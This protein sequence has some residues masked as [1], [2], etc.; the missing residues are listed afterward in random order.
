MRRT[1]PILIAATALVAIAAPASAAQP[2]SPAP[3]ETTGTATPTFRWT[4]QYP[5]NYS[6]FLLTPSPAVGG[7]GRMTGEHIGFTTNNSG[8]TTYTPLDPI[9]AGRGW[10]QIC[11]QAPDFSTTCSSPREVGIPIVVTEA[12]RAWDRSSRTVRVGLAGN[13]WR[14]GS[15][16]VK[17]KGEGL[18]A[19]GWS[20]TYRADIDSGGVDVDSGAVPR[21]VK[22]VAVSARITIQGV[23]RNVTFSRLRTK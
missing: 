11:E 17:L 13:F 9:D 3:G 5:G 7:D 4:A 12:S 21:R 10:W 1:P 15:V 6:T 22:S 23:S 14:G 16:S 19:L 20:R 18:R 2:V 8:E